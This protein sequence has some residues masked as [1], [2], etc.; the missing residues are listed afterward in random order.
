MSLL[1]QA[2]ADVIIGADIVRGASSK[3]VHPHHKCA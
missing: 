2:D 3:S 1:H